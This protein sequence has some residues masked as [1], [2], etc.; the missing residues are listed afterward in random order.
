[1]SYPFYQDLRDQT[2]V[3]DGVFGRAPTV[4]NLWVDNTTES[5]SG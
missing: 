5:V 3:F 4:V 2:D 1:M